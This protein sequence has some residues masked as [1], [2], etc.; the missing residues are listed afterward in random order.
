MSECPPF[1]PLEEDNQIPVESRRVLAL[2]LYCG[3]FVGR[4]EAEHVGFFALPV[5][6]AH[7]DV[8]GLMCRGSQETVGWMP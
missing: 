8:P 1:L 2:C 5:H 7:A 3:V 6:Q 4:L